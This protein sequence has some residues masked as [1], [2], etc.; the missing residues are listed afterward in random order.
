MFIARCYTHTQTYMRIHK[1][2]LTQAEEEDETWAQ[3]PACKIYGREESLE[4]A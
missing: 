4:I 1:A 3:Q 2:Q